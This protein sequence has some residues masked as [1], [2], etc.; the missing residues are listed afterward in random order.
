MG[1]KYHSHLIFFGGCFVAFVWACTP[2]SA[3]PPSPNAP[4]VT[5]QAPLMPDT[6]PAPPQVVSLVF[7]SK[8]A[9]VASMSK[10]ACFGSCPVFEAQVWADGTATWKGIK[11]VD[12]V[13]MF[14]AKVPKNWL[15]DLEV[16]AN[17][18]NFFSWLPH[19]PKQGK[20][21]PDLPVTTCFFKKEGT[22]N[23]VVDAGDA[24]ADLR[25]FEKYFWEQLDILEWE[26]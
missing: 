23:R 20:E 7:G 24:P 13:G 25:R 19:Y 2:K 11:N 9:L 8:P 14:T 6:V 17:E 4:L 15:K 18:T 1:L 22:E 10:T 21:V 26:K 16:K 3:P 12:R 5:A